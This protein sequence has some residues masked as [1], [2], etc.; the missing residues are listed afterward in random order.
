MKYKIVTSGKSKVVALNKLSRHLYPSSEIYSISD[1]DFPLEVYL[2]VISHQTLVLFST[3]FAHYALQN[4]SK[5]DIPE[6]EACIRLTRKW[7]EDQDS[8]SND[9]LRAARDRAANAAKNAKASDPIAYC[10]GVGANTA[11]NALVAFAAAAAFV[12]TAYYFNLWCCGVPVIWVVVRYAAAAAAADADATYAA[13]Y[14]AAN[15]A[16]AAANA[17]YAAANAAA[18]AAAAAYA[19]ADV[20]DAAN[21]AGKDRDK[22]L[23]R[24][25]NFILD[26]LKSGK[27]LFL[28]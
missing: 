4:Y 15:A 27:H 19:A 5:K 22:E 28:V 3:E 17:T 21:A 11:P 23:I 26:F 6:A 12:A 7:L 25:G 9:E 10:S 13:A 24:Q 1:P 18:T 20:A 2:G 16:V 8:V 14:A